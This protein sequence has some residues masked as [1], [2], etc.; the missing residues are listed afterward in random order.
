MFRWSYLE[1]SSRHSLIP[2]EMSL[3]ISPASKKTSLFSI[4]SHST[5]VQYEMKSFRLTTTS[6]NRTIT[7]PVN[8]QKR[9]PGTY[10]L[11]QCNLCANMIQIYTHISVPDVNFKSADILFPTAALPQSKPIRIQINV[12]IFT[13][14]KFAG[15]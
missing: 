12:P 9:I 11:R 5:K 1:E 10:L 4:L 6:I 3:G 7:I 15:S 14:Y 13:I 2:I 8:F